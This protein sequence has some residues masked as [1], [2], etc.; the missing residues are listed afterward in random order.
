[1]VLRTVD[2]LDGVQLKV[3]VAGG[4]GFI[5]SHLVD[6]LV[7]ADHDVIVLDNFS[8]GRT[9]NLSNSLGR[10][11]FRLVRADIRNIPRSLVKRLK[12]VDRVVHLAALTSVQGSIRDPVSTTDVNVVGT[13]NVLKAA[14][15]LKAER[16]VFASSAAVYG[17]PQAFPIAEDASISP[18]SPY[19]ASKAA[20][21]LYI[22]SFEEN[23]G[24]E[25]VSLRYF[26]VYGPRQ[27]A[28][29]YAG[30]I[31]IF[32]KRTLNQQPL[33]IFGDGSQTRDFIYI[34]DVVS[35][36]IAALEN[37]LKSRAF[38][39]AT[40]NE[41]TILQLAKTMQRITQSRSDLKLGPPR[42]GDIA[43]SV[44]DVTKA[45]NELGFTSRASLNQG[46]SATIEWLARENHA[47]RKGQCTA[48]RTGQEKT[49]D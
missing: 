4:A 44:A 45:R 3:L 13:L 19:G 38:N 40:G 9:T 18:I 28:G 11:N 21:E 8:T 23:H 24:V 42:S 26:N 47:K 41:I 2:R 14:K 16:V 22:G 27:T 1:V 36:T 37:P 15:A 31:S 5:G 43:R 33:H 29:Q 35:A 6:R 34:Y 20:S 49:D 46:L 39:I 17:A 12:R 48:V 30:V 25:G 10:P 32:A 7:D